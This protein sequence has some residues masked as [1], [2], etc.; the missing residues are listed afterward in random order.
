VGR[1]FP[2]PK[3]CPP[4]PPWGSASAHLTSPPFGSGFRLATS[5]H[6]SASGS[7]TPYAKRPACHTPVTTQAVRQQSSASLLPC[8]Q[9]CNIWG[10]APAF[11][12]FAA[13]HRLT[14]ISAVL[15]VPPAE[16]VFPTDPSCTPYASGNAYRPALSIT[17]PSLAPTCSSFS[18]T[19][20]R[21]FRHLSLAQLRAKICFRRL[22]IAPNLPCTP[23]RAHHD[24]RQ[25]ASERSSQQRLAGQ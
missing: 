12:A 9:S 2:I 14:A 6:L 15:N 20:T 24:R 22:S 18:Q 19:S 13:L 25:A 17:N 21:V 7:A 8:C 16:V 1:N 3:K 11:H 10:A 4:A 23:Y 5:A